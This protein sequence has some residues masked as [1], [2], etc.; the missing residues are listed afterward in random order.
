MATDRA[1]YDVLS[2]EQKSLLRKF[3][4]DGMKTTS[5]QMQE[6]IARAAD[7]VGVSYQTVKKWIGNERM[8]RKRKEIG[9]TSNS[10]QTEALP[11]KYPAK[12]VTSGYNMFSSKIL[13]S[14]QLNL[15]QRK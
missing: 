8:R 12:R 13:G 5:K 4:E 14:G 11:A 3:Y 15:R 7:V 10:V 1:G 9:E 6:R 2:D